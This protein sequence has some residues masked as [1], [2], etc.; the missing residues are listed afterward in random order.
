[1][2]YIKHKRR[3][4]PPAGESSALITIFDGNLL[5]GLL[6]ALSEI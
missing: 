6:I 1:M 3:L 4:L 2:N 5:T